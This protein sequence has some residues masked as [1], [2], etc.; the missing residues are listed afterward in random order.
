[1]LLF[2]YFV[3]HSELDNISLSKHFASLL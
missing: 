2:A 1:M 3:Y